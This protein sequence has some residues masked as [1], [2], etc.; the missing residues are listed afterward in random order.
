M[1]LK[2]IKSTFLHDTYP[3]WQGSACV[4]PDCIPCEQEQDE[5]VWE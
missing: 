3:F 1:L 4:A 2:Y 5:V